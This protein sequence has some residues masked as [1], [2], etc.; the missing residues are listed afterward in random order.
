M[1]QEFQNLGFIC[2]APAVGT[3]LSIQ[4]TEFSLMQITNTGLWKHRK[5]TAEQDLVSHR[6]CP[7]RLFYL[8]FDEYVF[9]SSVF[10]LGYCCY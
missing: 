1:L 10:K 4:C 8:I 5:L 2:K 7:L 9:I 3:H 6:V